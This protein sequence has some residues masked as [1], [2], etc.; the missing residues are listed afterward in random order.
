MIGSILPADSLS[1]IPLIP[2]FFNEAPTQPAAS[3]VAATSESA[4]RF[5]YTHLEGN[6]Q[7]WQ[8]DAPPANGNPNDREDARVVSVVVDPLASQLDF[9]IPWGYRA[10]KKALSEDDTID[11]ICRARPSHCLLTMGLDDHT[12]LPTLRKL[13]ERMPDLRYVAAP[14]CLGKLIEGLGIGRDRITV[15]D[16]GQS[17]N[18]S[19]D[20]G[21]SVMV[22]AT[23]GA[24]V[25]PPWQERENGY[26]L[27][28]FGNS[29][30]GG[31]RRSL[32][33]YYEPHGDVVLDDIKAMR[34]DVVVSPVTEQSLPAQ[35]PP[36]G[37]FT[38]VYGGER[39][40]QIA[41]AMGAGVIVPLGNGALDIE[42][43][44]AGLVL[45]SGDVD[46]FEELVKRR[47]AGRT[48]G[49]C[50]KVKRATPG[51]PLTILL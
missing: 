10:N 26:L 12:H 3:K 41:E 7:L 20:G 22:T 40:L 49:F 44:L 6:G 37:R 27:E 21:G 15:L 14:S 25:G 36:R 51:V 29:G 11:L 8:I 45:A 16:H 46:D 1:F 28:F 24:L 9:G 19:D 39:T 23:R 35:A 34:A 17:C 31:G 30:T 32:S 13:M 4:F 47:N 38:L 2:K 48:T 42:G 5:R 43:P 50:M 33:V 18:A